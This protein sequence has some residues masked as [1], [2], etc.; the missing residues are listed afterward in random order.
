VELK[1]Q[2]C[3]HK[4][5]TLGPILNQMNSACAF[6]PCFF[7][8]HSNII[9]LI[10]LPVRRNRMEQLLRFLVDELIESKET[11]PVPVPVLK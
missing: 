3:L 4:S 10:F 2:Y 8:K 6:P 5:L 9:Y 7:K 11:V 1:V